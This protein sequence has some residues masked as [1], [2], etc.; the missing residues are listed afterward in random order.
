MNSIKS[1]YTLTNPLD[2]LLTR[3]EKK[4]SNKKEIFSNK[5]EVR[6]SVERTNFVNFIT[7]RRD[8]GKSTPL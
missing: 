4:K 8:M 2:L 7:E 1:L 6:R 3:T 5:T